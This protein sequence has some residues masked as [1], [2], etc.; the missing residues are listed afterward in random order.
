MI[1]AVANL[2]MNVARCWMRAAA[3]CC[4]KDDL[5]CWMRAAAGYCWKDDLRCWMRA[6][7]GYCW[8]DDLRCWKT[9]KNW[10]KKT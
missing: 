6:A 10:T 4:W 9:E 5:R 7:A 8:K 3:G 1:S 2:K